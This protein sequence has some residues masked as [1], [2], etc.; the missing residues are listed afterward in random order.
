MIAIAGY[1]VGS[2]LALVASG[3]AAVVTGS[4][5]QVAEIKADSAPQ[6]EAQTQRPPGGIQPDGGLPD[7]SRERRPLPTFGIAGYDEDSATLNRFIEQQAAAVSSVGPLFD[8][9]Y[10]ALGDLW[11]DGLW[12]PGNGVRPAQPMQ[13]ALPQALA[14]LGQDPDG[15][16]HSGQHFSH[17][18]DAGWPFPMWPQVSG[19]WSGRTA[20]W[21]F[22]ENGPGWLW[23]F[24]FAKADDPHTGI[25]AAQAWRLEGIE[26]RGLREGRLQ[27]VTTGGTARLTSPADTQF[28]ARLAPFVQVRWKSGNQLPEEARAYLWW[29]TSEDP[30]FAP[31]RLTPLSLP[32]GDVD[33]NDGSVHCMVPLFNQK[34]W[35][36]TITGL[37]ITV[38]GLPPGSPLELDSVFTCFDT[39]HPANAALFVLACSHVARWSGDLLFLRGQIDR[40]RAAVDLLDR[41]CFGSQLGYTRVTWQGHDGRPGWIRDEAG[42]L[43]AH[44]ESGIG[45]N[46]F[47][48]LPF[49]YDDTWL[50]AQYLGALEALAEIEALAEAY[51]GLGLLSPTRASSSKALFDRARKVRER[52]G[53][54]LFDPARGRFVACIDLGGVPHDYG[55]TF[56]NLDA[57]RFGLA[58]SLQRERILSWLFAE[59]EIKTDTSKGADL[60]HWRFGL[61]T[62]TVRNV[63]WY[64]SV[65]TDPASVP[66]GGQ[67]QDGGAVLGFTY[68]EL[69]ERLRWR[70]VDDAFARYREVLAW[71]RE[72]ED[73]GG[74]RPYYASPRR[75][76][77]L[78]GCGTPGGLGLDCEFQEGRLIAAF[79]AHGL[80]GLRPD[81]QRL[82][83]RPRFPT[84]CA[85]LTV[86]GL[87]YRGVRMDIAAFPDRVDL[88]LH[89]VPLGP[90]TV[91][92][93]GQWELEQG[94]S[95]GSQFSLSERGDYVLRRV[96]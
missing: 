45:G 20:G 92:L 79:A 42:Q 68:F 41:S 82:W 77:T 33:P 94:R 28:E 61:R 35:T 90:I 78:Q 2:A 95:R 34:G 30:A 40:M 10:R 13:A 75:D 31:P 16:V 36:G 59:R 49:G 69:M 60:Y 47:D 18:H 71:Y 24:G 37:R 44:P 91:A 38:D 43:E 39:R 80:M 86:E 84:G 83:I 51:P 65:W 19:G 15:Y 85:K 23:Q 56:L 6:E 70:G 73:A 81:L 48:L 50:T 22:Q 52:G 67:V 9:E 3:S 32:R 72:I 21:H 76:G 53:A 17:A 89:D 64:A 8:L 87:Q 54:Q 29:T 1:L 74:F 4:Q 5:P 88:K 93:D 96:E 25:E 11:M 63:D 27:L 46:Y 58:N 62:T 26:S 66:F 7:P 55:Y 57:V 12:D 14:A